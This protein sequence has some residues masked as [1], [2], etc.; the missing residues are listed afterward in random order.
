[1]KP[2]F[3]PLRA[4][5]GTRLALAGIASGLLWLMVAWALL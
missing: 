3:S 4:G 2:P 1:M 5:V